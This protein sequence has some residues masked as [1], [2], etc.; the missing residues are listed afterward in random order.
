MAAIEARGNVLVV[1]GAGAGK[2][3]TLVD[4][5]LAWLLDDSNE[6]GIDNILMVTFT[7]AAAAE[8]RRRLRAGLETAP[9]PAGRLAEQLALLETAHISTLHSFCFHLVSEHFYELGL[10]PQ[11]RVLSNE[12]SQVLGRQTLDALLDTAYQS[13]AP[14]DLALQ[15]LILSQGSEGDLPVRE[16]I[17]RLHHYS[18]TLP[19]PAGWLAAQRSRF[20]CQEPEEWRRWLAGELENW[21]GSW[22][23]IL[24]RQSTANPNA[25]ACAAALSG[26][27]PQPARADYAAALAAILAADAIWPRPKAP[28]RE[29]IQDIFAEAEFLHSV[30]AEGERDPLTEDWEW[31]RPSMLALLDAAGRFADAF[32][33]AKRRDGGID[34]H[35]L[36][37]FALRLLNLSGQPSGIAEKWRRRFRLVFVDEFQDINA[38]QAAIIQALARDEANA[39]L[40]L[41][42]DVKQSI[43]R[44]RLA[45][46]GI[47][48]RYQEKWAAPSAPGRVLTLAENF[49]SHEG[50]LHFVNALFASIMRRETG[51]V[52][53]SAE[54]HLRFGAPALRSALAAQAG[55]PP[56]VELHLRY[57]G[58]HA[59]EE[60]ADGP[61]ENASEAEKEARMVGRRL[62]ELHGSPILDEDSLRPMEWSDMVVLLRSPRNK[63]EAYVKEFHRLGVPLAAAR[64]GFYDSLEVRDLTAILQLLDNPLQDLPLL[65]VLRSPLAGVSATELALIRADHPRGRLWNALVD[66]QREAVKKSDPA[67]AGLREKA[68]RFLARFRHWRRQSR[69]APVS[70]SLEKIID[71]THYREW[72]TNQDRGAQR[73]ANV[74]RF[75]RLAREFDQSRGESVP[76]FLRFL[77]A[78]QESEIEIEPPPPPETNAV[79][80]MSIHQSKGQEFPLVVVADLGKKFNFEDLR[81]RVMLDENFGLCPQIRPPAVSRF[82]PSLPFWLARRRQKR[83]LMGEEMRLLYVAMTRASRRLILAGT[84]SRKALDERWG[85]RAAR[86]RETSEIVAAANYLDWIGPWLPSFDPSAEA[87]A[88][89]FLT[90][91]IYREDPPVATPAAPLASMEQQGISPEILR[92]IDWTYPFAAETTSPAKASVSGLRRRL[93]DSDE[94]EHLLSFKIDPPPAF[95]AGDELSGSEIGSAHHTFLELISLRQPVTAAILKEEAQ[96]MVRERVLSAAQADSLDFDGLTRFWQSETGAQLQAHAA[97]VRRELPFTARFE[98]GALAELGLTEFSAVG[99]GE[100]V[101]VQGVID[102]AVVLPE[103]IWILDFKTDHF[104]VTQLAEKTNLYRPQLELYAQAISRIHSRP[105]TRRW[106][107]FLTHRST[108][109]L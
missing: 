63:A 50:I 78:Q 54:A 103:E 49:R 51:G 57:R 90:W 43:Y 10:D 99:P 67:T 38:V 91:R 59:E 58:R 6:G 105:V 28:L 72:L 3:R 104:P 25:A 84:A 71:T 13:G 95:A 68:G 35:D 79:R 97:A 94:A 106:L 46:P 26:L 37:Q 102:L 16:L 29:P 100:F 1:A 64:G 18:Q 88:N 86:P 56:P 42:G 53:Y 4:R 9:L 27:P 22:L 108:T 11:L 81:A 33:Q 36:E 40:F 2:T 80:L 73:C 15:Q 14:A 69:Q 92:Q 32:G 34:Y 98:A 41:V 12:E 48:V 74:E 20:E 101:I 52:E 93:F 76:R 62:R 47:F 45:D 24:Q 87:G 107:H 66:W 109:A 83:E 44:F 96:R 39:N 55:S 60:D 70:H 77:E 7:Q 65:A 85:A 61:I 5:C 23:R 8:M 75:L 82:Y 89:Q 21:R 17:L 19:D 30:C 31:A